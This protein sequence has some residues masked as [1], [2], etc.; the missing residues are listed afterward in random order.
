MGIDRTIKQLYQEHQ[1]KISDKWS[2]YLD[3]WDRL[4][5]PYRGQP[6]QLLEIGVQ[7]GGSLE[8]WSAYFPQAGKIIGCDID[9][10][11][12]QLAYSDHRNIVI[13][14]DVNSK[15]CESKILEQASAFDIIIDDGS[16]SSRDVAHSFAR[17]FPHLKHGG[18]YVVED[19][20]CSYWRNFGGGLHDPFS[21][22]AFFKRLADV[23]NYEHWRNDKT[24]ASLLTPF[25]TK[26]GI[27]FD[28]VDLT[29]IHSIEF[30]NSLCFIRKLSPDENMLGKRVIV[31]TVEQVTSGWKQLNN[32]TIQDIEAKII[33]DAHLD[34]FELIIQRNAHAQIVS[35]LEKSIQNL[36]GRVDEQ[37]HELTEIKNSKAWKIAILLR[38]IRLLLIP[39]NSRHER[40]LQRRK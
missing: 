24:T 7:N 19:L 8:I 39:I 30:V 21:A 18:V 15:D 9:E 27:A 31:G 22:M 1:G 25:A 3:E 13:I 34:V 14:G 23:V 32:S 28:D 33:D 36:T 10:K 17:Y 4:F 12:E 20:H 5:A 40:I 35:D 37:A 11:C 29:G 2:L 38:R 26:F 6:I 16:H